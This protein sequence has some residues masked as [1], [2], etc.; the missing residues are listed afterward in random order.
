MRNA[1]FTLAAICTCSHLQAKVCAAQYLAAEGTDFILQNLNVL[2]LERICA[3]WTQWCQVQRTQTT[4]A[5]RIQ[6]LDSLS[7][8]DYQF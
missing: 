8:T 6:I 2:S 3:A 7:K 5:Q 1:T 4:K